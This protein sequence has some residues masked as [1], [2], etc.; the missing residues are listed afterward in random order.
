METTTDTTEEQ[1]ET[2]PLV[3]LETTMQSEQEFETSH[4]PVLRQLS[5]ALGLLVVVF[6]ATYVG[7]ITTLVR[8][9]TNAKEDVIVEARIVDLQNRE[10]TEQYVNAF[11]G[12]SITAQSAFVWDVQEQRV[13]FNKNGDEQLPLASITKLMTALV[14]YELLD[15]TETVNISVDAI[16]TQGDSGFTDGESFSVRDLSDLTLIT[17]SNDGAV[18]LSAAAGEALTT[19][20]DPKKLF[21]EAM[22]L[23]AEE[24]GLSNTHFNNATGLDE[25]PSEAGAYG[26]A[27]DMAFLMEYIITHYPDVV[28]LTKVDMTTVSNEAGEY[29]LAKNTNEVVESIEGLI[30]SKTGFTEL[31]GGNL[32]VAFDAGLNHPIIVSVL[33]STRE[34]RFSDVLD[35]VERAR[36][37]ASRNVE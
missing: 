25:S 36:V 3:S 5:V 31:A 30:A 24:L 1:F 26:T 28:A 18:A 29:H 9:I 11:D 8:P 27:R 6:G 22:N 2:S 15:T 34:G 37:H 10:A 19:T 17:S 23:R 20:S 13:L 16:R 33:G 4:M 12:T 32:I 14:A 21:V 35:L 7:T